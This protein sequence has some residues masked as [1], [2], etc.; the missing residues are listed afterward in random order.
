MANPQLEH[1]YMRIANELALAFAAIKLPPS[2]WSCLW[3]ILRF[4][5]GF[6]K[7][8]TLISEET[9][10]RHTR[11][12]SISLARTLNRLVRLNIVL[13]AGHHFGIQKSFE[14]WKTSKKMEPKSIEKA[15]T[16][17]ISEKITSYLPVALLEQK[18]LKI[19]E[20]KNKG[21]GYVDISIPEAL[22]KIKR[23]PETYLEWLEF[24]A[25]E[26]KKPVTP[27]AAKEQL[28]FL[29][30][31][32]DP[33]ECLKQSIRN[34]WQG[35]FE[36]R[37]NKPVEAQKSWPEPP[38][39]VLYRCKGCQELYTLMEIYQH[40]DNFP[41]HKTAT[42]RNELAPAIV[43]VGEVLNNMRKKEN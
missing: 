4:T 18:I 37:G 26:K 34:Q 21:C 38:R 20:S 29:S 17:G 35:I 7:K 31:Q 39:K 14:M 32:N 40:W 33:I 43:S 27:R 10:L 1:G 41:E 28:A 11:L 36:F 15:K 12:S 9:F 5:Y 22:F 42:Y 2:C 3:V 8:N 30:I 13:R 16:D 19:K 24:R 6:G 25:Y 23:F